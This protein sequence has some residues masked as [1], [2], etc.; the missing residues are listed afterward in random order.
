MVAV[1]DVS[2]LSTADASASLARAG[3]RAEI[4]AV[5]ARPGVFTADGRTVVAQSPAGWV[6]QQL[7][8]WVRIFVVV[9]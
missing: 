3:I 4:V 9:P 5:R 8:R 1:P 7:A 6:T 2:G